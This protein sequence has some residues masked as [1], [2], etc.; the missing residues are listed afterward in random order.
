MDG[1]AWHG[2]NVSARFTTT[3]QRPVLDRLFDQFVEQAGWK[4]DRSGNRPP[5]TEQWIKKLRNGAEVTLDLWPDPTTRATD[6]FALSGN[7]TVLCD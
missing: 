6:H 3:L 5:D 2:A 4:L 7:V 1:A